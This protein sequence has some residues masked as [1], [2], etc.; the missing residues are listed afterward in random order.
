MTSQQTMSLF[1]QARM[2]DNPERIRAHFRYF[3]VVGPLTFSATA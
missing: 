1:E 2:A 3:S